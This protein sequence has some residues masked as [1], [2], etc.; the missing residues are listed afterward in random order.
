MP[1]V[2]RTNSV[3]RG[4]AGP[5]ARGRRNDFGPVLLTNIRQL[6]TLRSGS[7]GPRRGKEL[8]D[9]GIIEDAA[10]LCDAGKILSVGNTKDA[11]YDP[12]L[13]KNRRRVEEIDCAGKVVIPGFVDSHTHPVFT[14]PRLLDFEKR[15]AGADYEAISQAGG[16][17]RSSVEGVRNATRQKL[18]HKVLAAFEEM[19]AQGTT[20][21]EAKS[22]YGLSVEAELKSLLAIRDAANRWPGTVVPTLLG[23]HVVPREYEGHS[24]KY[25]QDV[26]KLMV[27]RA[28]REKLAKFVDVFRDRGAF[29][30]EE[31][32]QIFKAA[33]R[34]GLGVRAHVCQLTMCSLAP[35]LGYRPASLDHLDFV[36][37]NDIKELS[38]S[39]TVATLVPGANYYLGLDRFPPA[40]K[41]IDNGVAVALATDYNPGT[42]PTTSMPFVLSLASTHL[43]MSPAEAISSATINGACALGLQDRKG[44]IEP[45]KD[46]D[47]AIFDFTDYRELA[48]WFGSNHCWATIA[49]GEVKMNC[50]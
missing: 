16:G 10:V 33:I 36:A 43:K 46:A 2:S 25:V 44:T 7:T 15:I 40:R 35:L 3:R 28:A 38:Q 1:K 8:R 42:S 50:R 29:S 9:L 47:L 22:G 14:G 39:E 24:K 21:A 4:S 49:G 17:I 12:W 34:N 19:G 13:K 37:D 5:A 20:T 23:A 11:L 30:V 45:S 48:Y 18:A 41:L 27:P 31:A 26:C 32:E 6:L